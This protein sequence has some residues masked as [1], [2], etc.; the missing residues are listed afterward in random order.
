MSRGGDDLRICFVSCNEAVWGGS[1]EL[2][3][4]AALAAVRAGHKVS[5]LKPYLDLRQPP[6]KALG[7]AGCRMRNLTHIPLSATRAYAALCR[8][9]RTL[10]ILYQ[11]FQLWLTL[12]LSRPDLVVLSQGGNWDGFAYAHICRKLKLRYILISQKASDIHWPPDFYRA[13]CRALHGQAEASWFV[14]HHNRCLTE[15]QL[16]IT[17]P[18]ADVVRN[19]FLVDYAAPLAWPG[20]DSVTRLACIGRLY[21]MEK[22]QDILLRVLAQPKWRERPLHVDFYGTGTGQVALEAMARHLGLAN[23]TFHGHVDDIPAV[24]QSHH[25]LVLPSRCEGLPLVLVECMLVGRIAITTDVGGSAEVL[26]DN[27]T[28]F[29]A[30]AP[31]EAAFDDAMERAWMRRSDWSTIARSAATAIRDQVPA[32]P[33]AELMLKIV[34]LAKTTA[35]PTG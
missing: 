16:A 33:S 10:A 12:R 35:G 15:E 26:D 22:G 2:W 31:T 32:D 5:A 20:D 29:L 19:P 8:V 11:M 25:G 4:G 21:P 1:E 6:L 24:W 30:S 7:E 23:V 17:L 28:G 3:A 13:Q 34:D 18:H 14:S 9:S 27:T